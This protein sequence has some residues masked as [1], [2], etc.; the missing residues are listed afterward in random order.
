VSCPLCSQHHHLAES[1]GDERALADLASQIREANT[2]RQ[3][4]L[5]RATRAQ[6][7]L[8]ASL[9][10][11]LRRSLRAAK[12][13]VT[14][15]V[16]AAADSGD[17]PALRGMDRD[18]LSR[19]LLDAGLGDLVLDITE[20]ERDTLA[21]VEQ[22]LLASSDGFDVSAL[23]GIGQA[24]ADDTISGII[25]DVIVPDVQRVV[26][27]ALAGAQFTADPS[28]TIGSL[29]AALRSAEGRQ[30][31]EARTR[32]TSFGRELTAVA[33][34][35]AGVDHYLYTGPLDGI[36]RPF[37]RQLAGKVFTKSQVQDLRNYQ[38]EPPLVRGGGYNCRH[39][40]APVSEELIESAGLDRGTNADVRRANQAAKAAR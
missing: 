1:D 36:T 24:L 4:D 40:W 37:C 29:D 38:I 13:A 30:I 8:E 3:R 22:L 15:A 16:R 39:T 17:L 6:L 27:D 2:A 34:E 28:E 5:L 33:A 11:K 18:T 9:D 12:S 7:R 35:S 10:K 14:D 32:I 19:W 20:A 25:D 21:N 23:E 31:T 26:R